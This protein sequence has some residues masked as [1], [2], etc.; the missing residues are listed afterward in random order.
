MKLTKMLQKIKPI[1]LYRLRVDMKKTIQ[2]IAL[3]LVLVFLMPTVLLSCKKDEPAI[4]TPTETTPQKEIQT[5]LPNILG[6]AQVYETTG[7]KSSLLQQK[8]S[9]PTAVMFWS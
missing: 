1:L 8:T 5:V 2:A 4:T 6:Y 7:T 3:F 9:L